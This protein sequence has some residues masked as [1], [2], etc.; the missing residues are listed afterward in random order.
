[1]PPPMIPSPIIATR[2]F[3]M[4]HPRRF[5]ADMWF[6]LVPATCTGLRK[7]RPKPSIETCITSPSCILIP[8]LKLRQSV[9]KK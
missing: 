2:G 9:P 6:G 4:T 7:G 3:D 8:S 5:H 1:M